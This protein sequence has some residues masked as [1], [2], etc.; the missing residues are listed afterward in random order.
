MFG[1]GPVEAIVVGV[2]LLLL[3]G[4]K[5]PSAMRAL[6]ASVTEFK[7]GLDERRS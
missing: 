3:F 5:L 6:G 7:R 4:K 2:V 1:I